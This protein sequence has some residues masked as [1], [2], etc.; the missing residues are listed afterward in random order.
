M[1]PIA[2]S[3]LGIKFVENSK[4]TGTAVGFTLCSKIFERVQELTCSRSIS[5]KF[6]VEEARCNAETFR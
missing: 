1:S 5:L 2:E 3:L 6:L 4:I